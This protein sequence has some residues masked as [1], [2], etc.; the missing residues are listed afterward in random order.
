MFV[1]FSVLHHNIYLGVAV[2]V[3]N[4]ER[5]NFYIVKVHKIC[6]QCAR[7]LH[8]IPILRFRSQVSQPFTGLMNSFH[9]TPKIC[10]TF[11]CFMNRK[12]AANVHELR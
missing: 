11:T 7:V 1:I 8:T 9:E 3:E 2:V 12:P 5:P 6:E 10:E 4:C